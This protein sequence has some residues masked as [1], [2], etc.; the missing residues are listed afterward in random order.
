MDFFIVPT[1]GE[2]SSAPTLTAMAR[3][4]TF[5]QLGRPAALI[6]MDYDPA[7]AT[8]IS[9]QHLPNLLSLFD[10]LQKATKVTPKNI[11]RPDLTQFSG[12]QTTW[13]E[14]GY[15]F[16]KGSQTVAKVFFSKT[17]LVQKISYFSPTG[18]TLYTEDYDL[19]GFKSRET[20]FN[21]AGHP[22]TATYFDP[23]G[24][25]RLTVHFGK[26]SAPS[27]L[28]WSTITCTFSLRRP[29]KVTS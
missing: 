6:L 2:K 9:E 3:L 24:Q 4:Q 23:T 13:E 18:A 1:L 28:N 25:A 20:T 15:I 16:S 14:D 11:R 17:A 8:Y 26:L 29:C 22:I 21:E 10:Y 12:F 27:S 19:R 5:G 7:R